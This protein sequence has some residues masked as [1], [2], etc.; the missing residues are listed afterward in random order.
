MI[1]GERKE[2]NEEICKNWCVGM[3][4]QEADMLGA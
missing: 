1:K 2:E 4:N 3:V